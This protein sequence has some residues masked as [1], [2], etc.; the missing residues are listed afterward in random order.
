VP[1]AILATAYAAKEATGGARLAFVFGGDN[2]SAMP[3]WRDMSRIFEVSDLCVVNRPQGGRIEFAHDPSTALGSVRR[4]VTLGQPMPM[5]FEGRI[6]LGERVGEVLLPLC[7][8]ES[9][10]ALSTATEPTLFLM[11]PLPEDGDEKLANTSSTALRDALIVCVSPA[12]LQDVNAPTKVLRAHGFSTSE[13]IAHVLAVHDASDE[14]ARRIRAEG[15][16]HFVPPRTR[17]LM[18]K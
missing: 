3:H 9:E 5:Y 1:T 7:T 16:P 2:V 11:P 10:P 15:S 12:T 6:V 4:V 17:T 18:P 14:A 8:G 13:I